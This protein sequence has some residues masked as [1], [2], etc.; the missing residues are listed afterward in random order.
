M[1]T[2]Q[3]VRHRQAD[4]DFRARERLTSHGIQGTPEVVELCHLTHARAIR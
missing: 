1:Q 4:A 2:F 3:K